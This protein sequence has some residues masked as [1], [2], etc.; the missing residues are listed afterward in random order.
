MTGGRLHWTRNKRYKIVRCCVRYGGLYLKVSCIHSVMS[1]SSQIY[2]FVKEA[3]HNS[4]FTCFG[5][6]KVV[7][8]LVTTK[9]KRKKI[10]TI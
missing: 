5:N 4:Q 1:H 2:L 3:I 8:R 10:K 7:I 6:K 9:L